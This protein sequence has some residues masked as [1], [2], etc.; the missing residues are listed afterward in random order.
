[1]F[2]FGVFSKIIIIDTISNEWNLSL[3]MITLL[4]ILTKY[5]ELN[6]EK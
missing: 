6:I 1:M 2:I 4:F 5:I 3:K